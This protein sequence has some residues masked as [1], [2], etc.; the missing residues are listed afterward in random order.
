[1][2]SFNVQSIPTEPLVFDDG[3]SF[4]LRRCFKAPD[5]KV[6]IIADF[7]QVEARIC[8]YLAGDDVTMQMVRDGMSVYEVH[9]R[10]TMGYTDPMPL[11]KFDKDLYALAKARRLALQFQCG[12]QRFRDQAQLEYGVGLDW[13]PDKWKFQVKDFRAKEP[14][15]EALWHRLAIAFKESLGG[16]Y[17]IELPSGR[18]LT[19]FDV[20]TGL[21]TQNKIVRTSGNEEREVEVQ[22]QNYRARTEMGG[23]FKWVYGGLLCNNITQA[24]ARDVFG[25]GLL[26]VEDHRP[27]LIYIWPTHDEAVWLADEDDDTAAKDVEELLSIT[28]DWLGDC[29]IG[30]E[31]HVSKFYE[32]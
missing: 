28:P 12:W 30:A 14:K 1:M 11:K 27:D 18:T 16:N 15:I 10:L 19:Y 24:T 3:Q 29:P 17:E 22:R 4:D 5:G 13:T 9:A 6:F 31:V 20:S 32:K 21:K 26:R 25:E 23:K 8:P 7:A 2:P